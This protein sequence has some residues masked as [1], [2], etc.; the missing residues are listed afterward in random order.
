MSLSASRWSSSLLSELKLKILVVDVSFCFSISKES[1]VD[2]E[3][4]VKKVDEKIESCS[5]QD[6]ELHV[7]QVRK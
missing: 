3:A 5:Q 7:S 1:I 4:V 6:V 2:V